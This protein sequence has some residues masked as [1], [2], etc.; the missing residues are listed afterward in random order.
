TRAR[1]R[2]ACPAVRARTRRAWNRG[3]SRFPAVRASWRG[4]LQAILRTAPHSAHAGGG[5]RRCRWRV[6]S[7]RRSRRTAALPVEPCRLLSVAPGFSNPGSVSVSLYRRAPGLA[8]GSVRTAFGVPAVAGE[9]C[10]V[11]S[12][13]GGIARWT[14]DYGASHAHLSLHRWNWAWKSR[15]PSRVRLWWFCSLLGAL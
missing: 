13:P 15:P 2:L 8:V 4:A 7:S 14:V 12:A 10:A 11:P 3:R 9:A 5:A 6:L 1:D